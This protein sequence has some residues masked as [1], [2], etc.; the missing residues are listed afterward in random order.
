MFYLAVSSDSGAHWTVVDRESVPLFINGK[1]GK[2]GVGAARFDNTN[3]FVVINTGDDLKLDTTTG[4]TTVIYGYE[5]VTKVPIDMA[6]PV[7]S[8]E[9][10]SSSY[11]KVTTGYT[12]DNLGIKFTINFKNWTFPDSQKITKSLAVK[13]RNDSSI[14]GS[15]SFTIIAVMNGKGAEGDAYKL[16]TNVSRIISDGAEF[17]PTTIRAGLYLGNSTVP[18]CSF[19]FKYLSEEMVTELSNSGRLPDILTNVSFYAQGTYHVGT[20]NPSSA[21]VASQI[22]AQH[23]NGVVYV[24][25][26]QDG[27]FLD[28]EDIPVQVDIDG[29]SSSGIIADL[30]D[31]VG[32]IAAGDDHKLSG[33]TKTLTT[34]AFVRSGNGGYLPITSC[35]TIPTYT[36]SN[37]SGTVRIVPHTIPS[38]GV[39]Y[40]EFDVNIDTGN[41][42]YIDFHNNNPLQFDIDLTAVTSDNTEVGVKVAYSLLGLR[43]G[44]DGQTV[45]LELNSDQIFY[46]PTLTGEYRFSPK[47]VQARL[48]I[49]GTQYTNALDGITFD[50][51]N[52]DMADESDT[53]MWL[54]VGTEKN[55]EGKTYWEFPINDNDITEYE[56]LTVVAMSGDTLLDWETVQIYRNGVDGEGGLKLFVEPSEIPIPVENGHPKE[57][58]PAEAILELHSGT[59]LDS[60]DTTSFRCDSYSRIGSAI[61]SNH[62]IAITFSQHPS[63]SRLKVVNIIVSTNAD[64]SEPIAIEISAKSGS[65]DQTRRAVL[66][67]KP[68]SGGKGER[69]PK[70]RIRE[71][72]SAVTIDYQNG[73]DDD[74]FWDI[75]YYVTDDGEFGGYFGCKT[76]QAANTTK[77]PPIVDDTYVKQ[78]QA[79]PN[80]TNW[81]YYPDYDFLATKVMTVGDWPEGWVID[82]G[83]IQH[84]R[85]GVTLTAEGTVEVADA[86][87]TYYELEAVGSTTPSKAYTKTN[88][89]LNSNVTKDL[90]KKITLYQESGDTMVFLR[91]DLA[92]TASTSSTGF[93]TTTIPIENISLR[94]SPSDVKTANVV[95]SKALSK[96]FNFRI[97]VYYCPII[98]QK[99]STSGNFRA[100]ISGCP[101]SVAYSTISTSS[102]SS[103]LAFNVGLSSRDFQ[104]GEYPT[105]SATF[106]AAIS[107]AKDWM[108]GN[109]SYEEYTPSLSSPRLESSGLRLGVQVEVA[110][111][112]I[113]GE[114]EEGSE[115]L[116][117]NPFE[118]EIDDGGS[119]GGGGG[120]G[121]SSTTEIWYKYADSA[122]IRFLNIPSGY[123]LSGYDGEENL[124]FD[125]RTTYAEEFVNYPSF[126]LT[127]GNGND[128]ALSQSSSTDIK[129]RT[130]SRYKKDSSVKKTAVM[131]GTN[132]GEVSDYGKLCFAAG[133]Q[134]CSLYVWY[135]GNSTYRLYTK[136]PY[137]IDN[138]YDTTIGGKVYAYYNV[139]DTSRNFIEGTVPE[140]V[141]G[142]L[143]N[144]N[145][146]CKI[147][148]NGKDYT[149]QTSIQPI[150]V[151]D[152]LAFSTTKIYANGKVVTDDIYVTNGTFNGVVNATEGKFSGEINASQGTLT[153][154]DIVDGTFTGDI[155]LY[156]GNTF[157]I[158]GE[159]STVPNVILSSRELTIQQ[160]SY[161]LPFSG[162]HLNDT[163]SNFWGRKRVPDNESWNILSAHTLLSQTIIKGSTV[164][165]PSFSISMS[166]VRKIVYAHF[167]LH[168]QLGNN[169]SVRIGQITAQDTDDSVNATTTAT[170]I[171][172]G[173]TDQVFKLIVKFHYELLTGNFGNPSIAFHLNTNNKYI[174]VNTGSESSVRQF[175]VG[176][177]G[178][179]YV[180]ENGSE[181]SAISTD[182]NGTA[183]QMMVASKAQSNTIYT[184]IQITPS[185]L[186]VYVG[187]NKFKAEVTGSSGS[188]T[189]TLNWVYVP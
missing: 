1:E 98:I 189:R 20:L 177:N 82:K 5:G 103:S 4:Y 63:D 11:C 66:T 38:G 136:Y 122:Y 60:I 143:I 114:R 40:L 187:G 88:Y 155:D 58:Y 171:S 129:Y 84:L 134:N 57:N 124:Y 14:Q 15:V 147:S 185:N 145:G 184:G 95:V 68:E 128:G 148:F 10:N 35:A 126:S 170:S 117:P 43:A 22:Q 104:T 61:D 183:L 67:L 142:T 94:I 73:S 91:D 118:N 151:G 123:E 76:D 39:N 100:L 92:L 176:P 115:R 19:Y 174:T 25:V 27:V 34:K 28:S 153:H 132:E 79:N 31:D 62:D 50:I 36:D 131:N 9:G 49:D 64:L 164:T 156:G 186:V 157:S 163:N 179:S 168:Y 12:D 2:D 69:G 85:S 59:T 111:N 172:I 77:T 162:W 182:A 70:T 17:S 51:K 96:P 24:G 71:Y 154:V 152:N 102:V 7:P 41:G 107:K 90:D 160:S 97:N 46:D 141:E 6:G 101:S 86:D 33:V 110:T 18:G 167:E 121:S 105:S 37:G 180:D 53:E 108:T 30:T 175:K 169:T 93:T 165:I 140:L 81:E 48:F 89:S 54:G 113:E 159:N 16:R 29:G 78:G 80:D 133:V 55:V 166:F 125:R 42:K 144:S 146:T 99:S 72:S 137:T 181:M 83:K 32:V 138:T 173:N 45:L 119:G 120:G 75:V 74:A 188:S 130:T 13:F 109:T 158:Y 178:F 135:G 106:N 56:P 127:S 116:S 161:Q 149:L 44:V 3:P 65:E 8:Q 112:T 47:T 150:Y 87:R 139:F 21:N 52:S 23:G 26:F